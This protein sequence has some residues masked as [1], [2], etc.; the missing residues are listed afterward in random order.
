MKTINLEHPLKRGEIEIRTVQ[1][2]QPRGSGWL[3]GIKLFDLMQMDVAALMVVLP[4][5]TDPA[6][7]E[8]EINAQIHP[9]DLVQIGAEVASFL[10]PRS[11]TQEAST[12]PP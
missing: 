4:R 11:M 7:T 6:L 9:A 3:R 5:I 1:F 8:Q 10:A 12:P 2:L